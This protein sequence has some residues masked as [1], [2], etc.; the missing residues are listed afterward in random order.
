M[1]ILMRILQQ[2][3]RTKEDEIM[4]Q[5]MKFAELEKRRKEYPKGIRIQP[6]S[7]V[8]PCNTLIWQCEFMDIDSAYKTQFFKGNEE[9]K[10][11]FTKQSPY[12]KQMRI[13]FY[14]T[15]DN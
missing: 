15:L 3:D 5:E 8:E 6:I 11:L 7:A 13:K 4:V 12:F 1:S 9:H 14:Q 2:F 10:K